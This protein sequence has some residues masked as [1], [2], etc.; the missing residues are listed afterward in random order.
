MNIRV[1]FLGLTAVTFSC[2]TSTTENTEGETIAVE[3]VAV[4]TEVAAIDTISDNYILLKNQCLICHGG[5]L[6]HDA[7]IAPPMQ[8]IKKLYMRKFTTKEEFVDAMVAW[9]VNPTEE[10]SIMKGAV[11]R[12]N[13]MPK[14][15]S[16]E[17]DL[18]VIAEFVYDNK[19]QEPAWFAEQF[20]KMHGEGGKG[21]GMQ[22]NQN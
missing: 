13:I 21:M 2:G 15:A 10:T 18:R 4:T 6:P 3:E 12:F 17:E 22:K 11:K 1:L 16:S 19:L 14:P 9:G 7:I 8:G 20:K 5:N